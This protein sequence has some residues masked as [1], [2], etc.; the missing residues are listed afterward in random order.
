MSV[1]RRGKNGLQLPH[2]TEQRAIALLLQRLDRLVRESHT[3]LLE[4]V[5]SRFE[6]HERELQSQRRRQCLKDSSSGRDD[7]AAN[8][9]SRNETLSRSVSMASLTKMD[10]IAAYLS[11]T[12]DLPFWTTVLVDTRE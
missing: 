10:E 11:G 4:S 8:A 12:Y 6:I 1:Q 9:I 5:E 2:S 3:R 7:F